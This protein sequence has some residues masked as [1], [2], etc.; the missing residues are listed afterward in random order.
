VGAGPI[1][2]TYPSRAQH[3][4]QL[5]QRRWLRASNWPFNTR[6][7]TPTDRY[8]HARLYVAGQRQDQL[9]WHRHALHNPLLGGHVCVP[10]GWDLP[11]G[12]SPDSQPWPA[13]RQRPC[14]GVGGNQPAGEQQAGGPLPVLRGGRQ[15]QHVE[16]S[17]LGRS[18]RTI[19]AGTLVNGSPYASVGA[20]RIG[21]HRRPEYIW[22]NQS[23]ALANVG[24]HLGFFLRRCR[25]PSG[26]A[27]HIPQ[28]VPAREWWLR[29]GW[30][31]V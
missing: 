10:S 19:A 5:T 4:G 12:M 25:R 28:I 27:S 2:L 20:P 22:C 30:A 11:P 1:A 23:L 13:I 21:V 29:P 17:P 16:C 14:W 6:S 26:G 31:L 9:V 3:S 24:D 15:G 8:R 18:N 7:T